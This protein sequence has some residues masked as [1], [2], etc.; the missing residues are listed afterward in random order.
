MLR[1]G[2][3]GFHL[4]G[5]LALEAA[6]EEGYQIEAVI[7]L[8][9]DRAAKRSGAASYGPICQR[10][11]IS[12]YEVDNI[13][14]E[15]S[16]DLLRE[17]AL[18]VVIVLGWTQIIR[19]PALEMAKIGMIGAHASLLPHNRGRAPINWALINGEDKTG[20]SLIWL[21]A[22]VDSG[23]II[24]QTVIPIGPYDT[25]ASLYERVAESN[26]EMILGVLP[27]LAAG[28]IPGRIQPNLDEPLLPGR[29]PADGQIDWSARNSKVYDFVRA[30]TRPYPG[31]FSYLNGRR[32]KIWQCALLPVGNPSGTKPGQVIGPVYSP[33]E[34][35][36]G[37][38]V[39]CGAGSVI[40][41]ELETDDGQILKGHQ[42][43]DQQWTGEMWINE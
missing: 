4:E 3:I 25:C 13:N 32:W 34:E 39:A 28:E 24:D 18:D 35:A 30:L 29:R 7:T 42:L 15:S 5:I 9:P 23:N 43:S 22:S 26:R 19:P 33:V 16:V 41:L 40:L 12:L 10:F 38:Q 14:R 31:A 17:L 27:K 8:T 1:I 20:N 11:D 21:E 6:L 2:W 36:S 37:Q